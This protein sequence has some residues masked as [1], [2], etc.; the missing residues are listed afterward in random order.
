MSQLSVV[1]ITKNEERNIADCISFARK[2][3]DDIIVVDSGSVDK[4]AA[5]ARASGARVFPV[6]WNSYGYSRNFGAA[7]AR[8]DWILAL[9][10]DERVN[11]K[12]AQSINEIDYSSPACVYKFGRRNFIGKNQIRFGT[13]GFESITRIYNRRNANWDLTPVHEKLI[14]RE[15]VKIRISGSLDHFGLA[16]E[17][18]LEAKAL[19]YAKMSAF[20]YYQQQRTSGILRGFFSSSFGFFKS[21]FLQLGFIE[22]RTGWLVAK[23]IAWYSW[24]KYSL[25]HQYRQLPEV[26]E[27]FLKKIKLERTEAVEI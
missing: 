7:K 11:D 24:M 1:I 17:E 25:L 9:D 10:A 26:P 18:Q 19:Y 6:E 3:S 27:P 23:N 12:L 5:I 20:K 4:T 15:E 2:V 8:Y 22:G 16:N 13:A 21:Y 14:C